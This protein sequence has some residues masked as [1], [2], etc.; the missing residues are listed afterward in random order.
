[1]SAYTQDKVTWPEVLPGFDHVSRM[2]DART[3]RC[4]AKIL[5]GEYYV[6]GND[7]MI[8]TV[9]GSCVSACVRDPYTGFGGMNHFMLPGNAKR[10]ADRWGGSDGMAARYGKAAM[11]MMI[12]EVLK[13]GGIKNRL[14]LKLFGGGQVLVMDV[15]NVGDRNIEFAREYA[16]QEGFIVAAED[17][18]PRHEQ[19][20][21]LFALVRLGCLRVVS[22][23]G[24]FGRDQQVARFATALA[25]HVAL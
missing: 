22:F 14:E 8:T 21:V 7:E 15:N 1:M 2:W 4:A 6:T 10:C 12:N 24:P 3:E 5:P 25:R 18:V 16:E 17:M 23:L 20:L 19:P 11:E 13:H 9:L